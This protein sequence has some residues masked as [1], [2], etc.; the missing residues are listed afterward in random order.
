MFDKDKQLMRQRPFLL[1]SIRRYFFAGI[2]TIFPLFITS[3]III[4]ILQFTNRFVG[5]YI[6]SFILENY[7]LTIPGLGFFITILAIVI[8]GFL[9]SILIGRKLLP[10]FEKLLSKIP[11]VTSIYPSAKQLSNFLFREAKKEQFKKV[12]LVPYPYQDSYSIGFIT[13]EGLDE[14]NQKVGQELVTI[15][16]PLAP[17]PFS[18]FI[19][20]VPKEKIKTLDITV[21]QA[22]RFIVSGGV[23][24]P[25]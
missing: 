9:S 18:G 24:A 6:N 15:F 2:A 4:V 12:V 1:Q 22:I 11:F 16:V 3:Y 21:D 8:I 7:N 5:K 20:L 10:L 19:L 13:N 25:A 14:L 23:I 17:V